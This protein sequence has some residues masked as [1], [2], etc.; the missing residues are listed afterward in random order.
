[1]TLRIPIIAPAP[2]ESVASTARVCGPAVVVV[3][4]QLNRKLPSAGTVTGVPIGIPSTRRA[5]VTLESSLSKA[6]PTSGTVAPSRA[7]EGGGT[8]KPK[9][10]ELE[11]PVTI[12]V[13]VPKI[14]LSPCESVARIA[15]VWGPAVVVMVS[16]SKEKGLY[17]AEA[18]SC[19]LWH[20]AENLS[21]RSGS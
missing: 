19:G 13:R 2:C 17:S 16:H 9:G 8:K 5:T 11:L 18:R 6:V 1:M 4:S 7:T 12:T 20:W 21:W 14:V 15:R 10:G 3:V